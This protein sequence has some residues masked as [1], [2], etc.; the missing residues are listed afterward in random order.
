MKRN[1]TAAVAFHVEGRTN[2]KQGKGGVKINGKRIK[3]SWHN[4][5]TQVKSKRSQISAAEGG[6]WVHLRWRTCLVR[7]NTTRPLEY[8]G[9]SSSRFLRT[10]MIFTVCAVKMSN[11][12]DWKH[13]VNMKFMAEILQGAFVS[14][15]DPHPIKTEKRQPKQE[16]WVSASLIFSLGKVLKF[17]GK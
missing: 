6:M 10:C 5:N 14:R 8:K 12:F 7:V 2:R 11:Y 1:A 16:L 3:R 15:A 13:A 4:K 17:P 9:A